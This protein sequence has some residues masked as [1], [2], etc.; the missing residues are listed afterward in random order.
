MKGV[1]VKLIIDWGEH[2]IWMGTGIILLYNLWKLLVCEQ[3]SSKESETVN[4]RCPA[5]TGWIKLK[6]R[7][8][9]LMIKEKVYINPDLTLTDL[10]AYLGTNSQYISKVINEGFKKNYTDYINEYRIEAFIHS[11]RN[12]RNNNTFL[13]HAYKVGF[14]SK[15]AFNRAFKKKEQCTPREFFAHQE[16]DLKYSS[17]KV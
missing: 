5:N 12:D 7:L 4:K 6:S 16:Q 9:E 3:Y 11:V 15:S 8:T 17:Q 14:N 1:D 10:A 2:I 13:Y